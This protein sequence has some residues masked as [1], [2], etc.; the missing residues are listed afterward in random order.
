[1]DLN[2]EARNPGR[3]T[4]QESRNA[5]NVS[6]GFM[7]SRSSL[8]FSCFPDS[9]SICEHLRNLWILNLETR[10]PGIQESRKK[11]ESIKQERR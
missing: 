1:V 10:N 11:R 3:E 8:L 9:S 6:P 5:G 7:V 2:L 4:N